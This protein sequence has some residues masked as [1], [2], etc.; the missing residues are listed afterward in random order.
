MNNYDDVGVVDIKRLPVNSEEHTFNDWL[1]KYGK[2]HILHSQ[3]NETDRCK[4]SQFKE[5]CQFCIY[6]NSLNL[7][8]LPEMVFPN[9]TLYLTHNSGVQ[10]EFN[11]L[12][13]LKMV[14]NGKLD[15][16]VSCSE[17]WMESRDPSNLEEKIKPFDWTFTTTYTGTISGP[18]CVE[19]T[20]ERINIERLK[21]REKILFYQ[22]LMLFEDEL[23]DNGIAACTVKIRVMP[24]SYFVL[25]RYFLRVDGVLVRINDT[26]Y[27][28]DFST[29]YVLREYTS[30]ESSVKE[31]HLPL[32]MFSDPNLI[33]S[34]IPICSSSYE[35]ITWPSYEQTGS[36]ITEIEENK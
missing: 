12:D 1:I 2:S 28:H 30:K 33:S 31:L 18:A 32:P 29:N 27:F 23:H 14:S 8:H 3:C 4:K 22:E 11:A 5:A 24:S 17:T 26:R 36:S 35:R 15:I 13:A 21:E 6:T 25:L 20:D 7:S 16:K 10:I 9:N 34:Y 19:P